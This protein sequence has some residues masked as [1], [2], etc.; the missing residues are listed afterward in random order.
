[1]TMSKLTLPEACEAVADM[2]EAVPE[3]H[4]TCVYARNKE[5]IPVDPEI[6][7]DQCAWCV[8]GGVVHKSGKSILDVE[9]FL[10]PIAKQLFGSGS[11]HVNDDLGR[12]AAIRLLREAA[13]CQK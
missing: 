7:Q 8:V 5:G 6:S 9:S 10:W 11:I 1:M 13:K 3:T 2:F 4:T 12:E